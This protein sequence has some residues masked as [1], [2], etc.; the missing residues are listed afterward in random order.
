MENIE[1]KAS[2]LSLDRARD[3]AADLGARRAATVTQ[4]DTYFVVAAGRLKLREQDPGQDELI[5]Y[6]RPDQTTAKL[7]RYE[8]AFVEDTSA[9]LSLLTEALGVHAR[10]RKRRE[11]W[12]LDNVRI[13]LD[14]VEALGTYLEFEVMVIAG[15][16]E[17]DC[18]RR[19][20][21]LIQA[22]AIE[23]ADLISSSYADLLAQLR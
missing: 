20:D 11:L 3:I 9:M 8:T 15:H 2:C 6:T 10:V 4:I 18:R 12:R 17:A 14:E 7:S 22:F 23:A 13:H 1:I 16:S 5:F 21:A 19:A